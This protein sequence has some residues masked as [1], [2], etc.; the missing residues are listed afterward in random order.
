MEITIMWGLG[1]VLFMLV[2]A[3]FWKVCELEEDNLQL[4]KALDSITEIMVKERMKKELGKMQEVLRGV[5][6]NLN[7]KKDEPSAKSKVSK[8]TENKGGDKK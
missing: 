3:L 1:T 2:A 6:G 5:F 4:W 8:K 7:D